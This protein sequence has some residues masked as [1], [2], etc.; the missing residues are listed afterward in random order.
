[1]ANCLNRPHAV[2]MIDP[3]STTFAIPIGVAALDVPACFLRTSGMLAELGF[4]SPAEDHEEDGIDLNALLIRNAPATFLYRASG[5]SMLLAGIR[6]G[7]ILAVDRSVTPRDRDLVLASWDGNAPCCKILHLFDD[8]IELH[9]A[10]ARHR[11]IVFEA[12]AEVEVFAIVAVVRQ[13]TRG[14]TH[15]V[16]TG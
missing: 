11:P 3:V 5:D 4:P 10:N 7:D 14:A 9:S 6:D 1:M 2:H 15:R 8:H 13:V 16:R 12:G